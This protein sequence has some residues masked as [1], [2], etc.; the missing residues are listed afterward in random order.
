M[1]EVYIRISISEMF[2]CTR[3]YCYCRA[4]FWFNTDSL[5]HITEP[6]FVCSFVSIAAQYIW[7]KR[8]LYN[9]CMSRCIWFMCSN[10]IVR[11]WHYTLPSDPSLPFLTDFTNPHTYLSTT[12]ISW[13]SVCGVGGGGLLKRLLFNCLWA[14]WPHLRAALYSTSRLP[15]K[16]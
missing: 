16:T 7:L 8:P 10:E 9:K 5:V 2:I 13:R 15:T 1:G 14:V 4:S 11:V 6:S 12:E 3:C